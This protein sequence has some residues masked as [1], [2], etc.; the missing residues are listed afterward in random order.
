MSAAL[1]RRYARL[2]RLYPSDYQRDRGPELLATLLESTSDGRT[3]PP[4]RETTALILGALRAHAGHHQGGWLTAFRAAALMLLVYDVADRAVVVTNEALRGGPSLW[5]PAESRLTLAALTLGLLAV[6]AALANRFLT[7]IATAAA[8]FILTLIVANSM[9]SPVFSGFWCFPLAIVLL[10][11]LVRR[12]PAP[13]TALLRYAPALPL[14]LIL[15]SFFPSVS[16][17]LH[18]GA[19]MALFLG[20]LLWLAIDERLAMAAGLFLQNTVLIRAALLAGEGLPPF[21]VLAIEL[22]VT[23][24]P[25]LALLVTAGLVIPRW[26]G[27][28]RRPNG[29]AQNG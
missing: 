2:L 23:A 9:H 3:S 11:P 1:E 29:E 10:V 15:T 22:A 5:S 16:G 18:F 8:A 27:P 28:P 25:P 17:I 12:R 6:A 14:V 24:L 26:Y 19:V 21:P 13:A 4:L 20:S 7:A